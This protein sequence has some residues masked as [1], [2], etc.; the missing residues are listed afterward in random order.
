MKRV[1]ITGASSGIGQQLA[2]DY[3]KGGWDVLACGRDEQRLNALTATFPTIRTIAFDMT[4]LA[5]TQQVL[6]G[7]AA[8]L[9]ILSAGTCEYLDNGVVEAEKVSRVLTTNVIGPVNCLSVLLPQLANG[10]HLALVGSTA[11]LVALPRA[12]AYGASKAALAY[13]ARSLSLDLQ[14]RNI[15]VSL[16]LPGFV[17]TPLTARNDFPMPMLI[18]VSHASEA[19]RRGL[20]KKKREI[21]FPLRFALLLNA[22]SLL[23][24]SWQRLLASRLVR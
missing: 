6:D 5:D 7:V 20:A 16:I 8:D 22:I 19:I 12:E 9:V 2:L 18:S 1:L 11:S 23:P 3:A 17:D 13:F 24:Q 4:N 15:T 14:A 10:S 21:A